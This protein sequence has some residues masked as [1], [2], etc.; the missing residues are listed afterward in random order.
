MSPSMPS[1]RIRGDELEPSPIVPVPRILI[2]I[3]ESSDPPELLTD[4]FRPGIWP[5]NACDT[6]CTGR[7][8][9]TSDSTIDTAPVTFTFFCTP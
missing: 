9:N 3:S 8:S 5:C 6:F 7:D 1:I 4:K 2:F